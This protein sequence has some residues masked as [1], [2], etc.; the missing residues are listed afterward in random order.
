MPTRR[1]AILAAGL[2]GMLAL[3]ACTASS[4]NGGGGGTSPATTAPAPATTGT[5]T[6]PGGGTTN[7]PT[8][9]GTSTGGTLNVE[10]GTAPDSL[11]PGFGYTTQAIEGDNQVYTPLLAY[12]PMNGQAGTQLIP[13]LAR[14]LPT[15]SN[16]GLTY[17]LQLRPNLVYSDGSPVK[18]SDVTHAIERSLKIPWGGSGFFTS[19]IQGAEAYA[20][21][22]AHTISG[23]VTNDNTGMITFHLTTAYGAFPNLIA[24]PA[25]APVPS[26]TPM[27]ALSNNPPPGVGP[28][29]FKSVTPSQGYV[30][31]RNP[32]WAQDK[33][34]G[35][36]AGNVDQVDV[37]VES[38]TLTEAQDVLNGTA[39][40]FDPGDTVPASILAQVNS[41]AQ[42]RFTRVPVA[43]MYYF[44]L[45]TQVPPFNNKQ[46]RLAVN[47]ALDR[48]QFVALSSGEL[49]PACFFLPPTIVGHQS[50]GCASGNPDTK[51]TPAVIARAKQMIQQAGDAGKNVTVFS[52]ERDPRNK[53]SDAW[54][55]T[56]NEL[57]FHATIR[58][59]S[60][61][62][63]FQVIGN[64]KSQP[65]TG[66]ADWS[67][68][69]PNP[70]DFYLLLS[71]AG[72]QDT[73]NENF[74]QVN[75]P[76]IEQQ[77]N[78]LAPVPSTQLSTVQSKWQALDR[79]VTQQGFATVFGYGT[80]PKFTSSRVDYSS[81]VLNPVNYILYNTVTLNS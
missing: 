27:T 69:F 38:N 30:L 67:Q 77:L 66:F 1:Y 50:S 10:V 79:Y 57:G 14:A 15:V 55:Q 12:N 71:K 64:R 60:D 3:A 31:V 80:V 56:L 45:N 44:F 68:D 49:T 8:G 53:Y 62:S 47:M 65:Q 19:Y 42:G 33:I 29:M 59:V 43:L 37:K 9:G 61:T 2:A 39:D 22:H 40:I 74:G 13:G 36:P 76:H 52:E 58:S 17:T 48:T 70:I 34:T 25:S 28:Y 41:Q 18:A 5:T 81:L 16:N 54:A 11:D 46:V 35:I 4:G 63:Y 73:N 32:H 23:I 24:F 78:Q 21:N 7:S 6:A 20:K 72:I 75:D 51:P 26:S